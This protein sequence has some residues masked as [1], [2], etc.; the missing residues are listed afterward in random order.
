MKLTL[1]SIFIN[2]TTSKGPDLLPSHTPVPT[3]V[4][5]LE[6]R[7]GTGSRAVSLGSCSQP[8][9]SRSAEEAAEKEG[10]H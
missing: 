9:E 4:N 10:L 1:K 7:L 3:G 5:R 6:R 8:E 2:G